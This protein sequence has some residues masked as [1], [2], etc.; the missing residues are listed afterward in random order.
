MGQLISV[1]IN[2]CEVE[3]EQGSTILAAAEKIGIKIPTLC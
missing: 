2:G 3:V 1:K